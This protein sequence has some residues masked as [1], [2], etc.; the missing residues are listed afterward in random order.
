MEAIFDAIVDRT[1]SRLDVPALR[2][3][4]GT[5]QRPR[6]N[7]AELSP[8]VAAVTETPKYGLTIFKV[9]FGALTLKGYTK[10][11]HVLRFEAVCH[12]T[13]ALGDRPRPGPLPRHRRPSR[14]HARALLHHP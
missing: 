6:T 3:L 1:R 14:R 2:T 8:R 13:K 4:F 9:H 10:G 5:K 7:R 12:N 11:E